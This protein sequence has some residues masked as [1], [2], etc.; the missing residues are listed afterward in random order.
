MTVQEA[1]FGQWLQELGL[2]SPPQTTGLLSAGEQARM[3]ESL[4]RRRR[5]LTRLE[6]LG[7]YTFRGD[8]DV[9]DVG[10][11]LGGSTIALA[12]RSQRVIGIEATYSPQHGARA[13]R[14][15]GLT[16]A[17][18]YRYALINPHLPAP[19]F[20]VR[21]AA[22]DVVFS[23]RGMGRSDLWAG[24][25]PLGQLLKPGGCVIVLYPHFWY[26]V[27]PLDPLET[28]LWHYGARSSA[29]WETYTSEALQERWRAVG[30]SVEVLYDADFPPIHAASYILELAGFNDS[31]ETV[32]QR[33]GL[34]STSM[35]PAALLIGRVS[36]G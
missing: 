6:S 2:P 1:D 35:V 27:A 3:A 16:N 13:L 9:L 11:G 18:I 15:Y 5:F 21:Q 19:A 30:F 25:L 29:R 7:R 26:P 28:R 8:E 34:T 12:Q 36:A 32:S 20:P 23:Y 14:T 17:V 4:Q 24:A 33:L 31:R 22:F 10:C